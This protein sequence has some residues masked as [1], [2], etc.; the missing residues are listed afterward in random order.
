VWNEP[1]VGDQQRPDRFGE[2]ATR[3]RLTVAAARQRGAGGLDRVELIGL[4]VPTSLLPVRS[5]DLDHRHRC[6]RQM[7]GDARAIGA[8]ALDTKFLS[9]GQARTSREGD[10]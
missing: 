3:L 7:A 4:A 8:G 10:Q 9:W 2:R 5:I 1:N 6:S